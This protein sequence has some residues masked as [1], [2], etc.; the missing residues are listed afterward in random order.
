M[1]SKV[2]LLLNKEL[3]RQ[4]ENICLIASENYV[5]QDILAVTGS[6]LTNKYAEGYPSKRFYRGCEVV[7]ESENLAIESCK[8]LFGAQWANV[9]PHSG[10]SANYAVYLALLK[11]GDTILGLDL[12]CGGHLTHGSPVNFSGKQYQA[13]TYSLDFETETLDYDAI[14]QIAIEHKPK[15]IICGFSNYSRTVD[16]KK[17]SAIA[18]Q[19]NAYLLADI[20]H[21]AGFIAAGLHQ[22]PLPF[23]DIVTSTTHKTLRGPRGGIIM[24]NNQAII[25]K[26]DSGVFPGCQGGPLQHVIAAKY[27]CFKE[28]LNPKFKQYMQQVKDNALAMAN[29][30][31]KQGYRVVSKGTETHLFSLVVGNGK[32]V[33][34]WLQ[35]ANIVLNMNTIPFETKSAFSPSGIRLGTPAMTT[36]GFKTNDFIFVASLIDKVIK[37]NGN[38]KVISQT[39]TTVLNLLKR[40]PLYKGLAY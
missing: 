33:A 21:I 17:F 39:K 24:S 1:F 20:A 36:R 35:K 26:L 16:F 27:V 2:R 29:W 12:N 3:Q 40:F 25:K 11:P 19:V 22:N 13:V 23:V 10:S 8:T 18:K 9:Q 37:S 30:F 34:L 6:V 15:L 32:D 38:Q 5:S 7:D 28:A 31:L 4:R 14:L